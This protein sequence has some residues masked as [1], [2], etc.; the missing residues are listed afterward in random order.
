MCT[1]NTSPM[2]SC[3]GIVHMKALRVVCTRHEVRKVAVA[4]VLI[5]VYALHL[6]L[7]QVC[8][9]LW[10]SKKQTATLPRTTGELAWRLL[11]GD[12]FM[13]QLC[14]C[15]IASILCNQVITRQLQHPGNHSASALMLANRI[16]DNHGC[17]CMLLL[18]LPPLH[19]LFDAER[20]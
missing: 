4:R 6:L 18:L 12:R 2:R 16:A 10:S 3:I 19:S 8:T 15:M 1:V 11:T 13:V 20:C 5:S 17:C 9:L 14:D 7:L